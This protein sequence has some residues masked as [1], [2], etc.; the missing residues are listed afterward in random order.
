MGPV[1]DRGTDRLRACCTVDR[2]RVHFVD[3]G[4]GSFLLSFGRSLDDPDW[5]PS[6][7]MRGVS[8]CVD[9]SPALPL[10]AIGKGDRARPAAGL[11]LPCRNVNPAPAGFRSGAQTMRRFAGISDQNV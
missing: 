10:G 8:A 6:W 3:D 4:H 9:V 1:Q 2:L 5:V 7:S 11:A